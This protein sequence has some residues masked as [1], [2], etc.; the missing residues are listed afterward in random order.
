MVRLRGSCCLLTTFLCVVSASPIVKDVKSGVTYHGVTSDGVDHFLNIP[1]GTVPKRFSNPEVYVFA[2]GVKDYDASVPGPACPQ[3]VEQ[4]YGFQTPATSQSEDCLRLKVARPADVAKD[5][6]LPVMVWIYGGSL[7]NG[8]INDET[9]NP[10]GLVQQSVQNGK[11]VLFVAMN[12]R[13]NIFGFAASDALKAEKSLNVGLKDQRLALQW[14]QDHIA[15]FGGDPTRVTLFGHSAGGLSVTLQL[16]AYGGKG[17]APFHSAIMQS[18]TIEPRITSTASQDTF[19]AVAKLANCSQD[20]LTCMRT[21]PYE[22]L[23]NITIAQRSSGGGVYLPVIDNDFLPLAPSEMI[24]KGMFIHV[25]A[26]IGWTEDDATVFTDFNIASSSDTFN[27]L[28]SLYSG[29]SNDTVNHVLSLYPSNEFS[30]SSVGLSAEFYRAARIY[31]DI[32][33]VCPS[34]FLGAAA[35]SRGSPVYYY[36]QNQT[37]LAD[38]LAKRGL[39][40][41]GIIHASELAYTFAN[42]GMYIATGDVKPSAS[43]YE[44]RKTESTAWS[45]FASGMEPSTGLKGWEKAYDGNGVN[46]YVVG[47]ANPGLAMLEGNGALARER[48]AERCNFFNQNDI[49]KQL[50]W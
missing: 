5:A 16:L 32:L 44:L 47:G 45:S 24:H 37:I 27:F 4:S 15:S 17:S 43:D 21:L 46:V 9:Y 33:F 14:V 25:P 7:F 34:L 26:I 28:R 2:D 10:D 35:S 20:T 13:L 22:T 49:I 31:R 50:Q 11:P 23:L 3:P 48:L 19:S 41:V 36:H 30:A 18:E 6:K 1:Y 38:Y 40:G 29:L 39:P 42:F 12:Y 8:H